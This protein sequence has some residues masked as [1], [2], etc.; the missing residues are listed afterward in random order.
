M[1]L[2]RQSDSDQGISPGPFVPSNA[3]MF[4]SIKVSMAHLEEEVSG[5][6]EILEAWQQDS[7]REPEMEETI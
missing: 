7:I 6:A 4:K 2:E 5:M 3:Q 1:P